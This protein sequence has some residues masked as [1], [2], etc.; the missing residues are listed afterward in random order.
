MKKG[1]LSISPLFLFLLLYLLPGIIL[2]DFY[3]MPIVVAFLLSACYA[4][5]ITP[6]K[7]QDKLAIFSRESGHPD[8]MMMIWIFLLAGAFA[9]S[10][11]AM[12]AVDA[13]VGLALHI[14]PSSLLLPGMFLAACF[15]SLA[16]GTSVGTIAALTPVAVGIATEASVSLPLMVAL[17]VGGAYFGDN[18]SFIS[19]TTIAATRT[20][21]CR[22]RDKFEVN[23]RLVMPT[24]CLCLLLY[25][26]LGRGIDIP[27]NLPDVT[28]VRVVPYIVVIVAALCGMNVMMVLLLG[29]SLCGIIGIAT[30]SYGLLGW[31]Q[32]ISEG[33][34]GM[35]ELII[36]TLLASGMLA[37]IRHSGGMD[38]IIRLL[39]RKAKNKRGGEL[40]IAA[41]TSVVNLC[42]A[43]NTVAIITA[44]PIARD[45][46]T[47]FKIDARRSASLLDT[48]S[49]ITQGLLPYGAQMLIASALAT[50]IVG[51]ALS[52]LSILPH[53]YYPMALG[54]TVIVCILFRI[55]RKYS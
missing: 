8:V 9:S 26:F 47:R 12:G 27:T 25:Y 18:L 2:G 19:D 20:Q 39:T 22:M 51:T 3:K 33:M 6:G 46:A 40:S 44:G 7:F 53:L 24:A 29:L 13:T 36:M 23:F 50:E 1:L 55:P 54:V 31:L 42:T 37:M 43:N 32:K 14:L 15:I 28:F 5:V 48:A 41:L 30:G 17:I 11:K 21:G 4:I 16:I 49:C 45:I 35:S 52:P 34:L 38:F 10:A